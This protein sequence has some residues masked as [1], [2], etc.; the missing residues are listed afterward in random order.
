MSTPFGI[1]RSANASVYAALWNPRFFGS[2]AEA[3]PATVIV[4]ASAGDAVTFWNCPPEMSAGTH[5]IVA[6]PEPSELTSVSA[7]NCCS[8]PVDWRD[9]GLTAKIPVI[10]NTSPADRRFAA[11]AVHGLVFRFIEY[12]HPDVRAG[13][14]P[15]LAGAP[16]CGPTTSV[17]M[18]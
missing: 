12:A 16:P 11:A 3:E 18:F 7:T 5:G 2:D 13:P 6:L 1:T 9:C 14:A 8:E 4:T 15:L 17:G 10:V